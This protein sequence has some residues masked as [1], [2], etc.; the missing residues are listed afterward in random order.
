MATTAT[1][2]KAEKE[3]K[4]FLLDAD[5]KAPTRAYSNA[6]GFDLYAKK[7][8]RLT[9][10][11]VRIIDTGIAV[12]FPKGTHGQIESRS[13]LCIKPGFITVG[14]VIDSDYTGE[15]KVLVRKLT[16]RAIWINKG[17]RFAQLVIHQDVENLKVKVQNGAVPKYLHN[18]N[19]R[20]DC[21][22]GSTGTT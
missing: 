17:D 19:D 8:T 11:G 2:E 9:G 13:S 18:P 22:L 12:V 4:F 14:G 21:G 20:G 3:L 15:I 7:S 1:P 10:R 16:S 6:A 5:A